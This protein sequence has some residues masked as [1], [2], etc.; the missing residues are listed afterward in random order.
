MNNEQLTG[1]DLSKATTEVCTCGS[2]LFG[3]G[4]KIRRMSP[5]VS[6]NGQEMLIPE[7]VFYC[8][9]CKKEYL[10]QAGGLND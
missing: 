7:L 9:E 8:L 6:P 4:S 2:E 1:V 10:T 5:I 3:S